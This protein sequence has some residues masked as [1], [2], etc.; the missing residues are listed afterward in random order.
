MAQ[1][2]LCGDGLQR[3]PLAPIRRP[4]GFTSLLHINEK[5]GRFGGTEEYIALLAAGLAGHGVRSHLACGVLGGEAPAGL[6]SVHV[7]DGLAS[8]HHSGDAVGRLLALVE[9]LAPDV[10]YLHN[11][12]DPTVVSALV[13]MEPRGPLLWY[14]H[15]H[16]VTCL[17]ELRWR[18]DIGSCCDALGSGCLDYI[19]AGQCVLRHPQQTY[20]EAELAERTALARTLTAADAV[21]VVSA[22]MRNLLR[23]AAPA[24]DE[25]LHHLVRPIRPVGA[26]P[27]TADTPC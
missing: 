10:I 1:D 11:L 14:V 9:I 20:A 25:R 3:A 7:I 26:T 15:D 23:Q 27:S 12:F 18:R 4:H 17:S 2:A 21:I 24:V 16:Y 22:Y 8:R 6:D 13:D 5:G 19:G